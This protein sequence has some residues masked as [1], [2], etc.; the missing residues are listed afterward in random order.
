V[1]CAVTCPAFTNVVVRALPFHCTTEPLIK[2]LP[3]TVSVNP[4]EPALL[5]FGTSDVSAGTGLF[6]AVTLKLTELE[7]PPPGPGFVTTTAGVPTLAMS[8][9]C[10]A[11]V[12]CPALTNVTALPTPP[13]VAVAP[14][15]KL[16]PFT[17]SVNPAEPAAMLAGTSGGVITGTGLFAAVTLKLTELEAPPPGV[18]FVTMTAGVPTLAMSLA[19]TTIVTCPELTKV[20]ALLA[21]PN[22]AVAPF[23]KLDPFTVSVN[24]APPAVA[25]EG[26]NGGVITG[27]GLFTAKLTEFDAPPPGPGFVTTT[28]GV[29]AVAIS[30]ARTAIV[31]CPE[32]TKVTALLTPPNVAVAPFTKFDPFTVSVNAAPPAIA[33]AGAS[34]AVITGTGL[35]TVK[36][37]EFEA[38]PPG[39]GFVTITAGV[40]ATAM[41]LTRIEAFTCPEFTKAVILLMPP[42]LTV[43]PLRK[44][45]PFTVNVKAAPPAIT[46]AGCNVVTVGT[47]LFVTVTLK[48]TEFDV[49]P[50]GVG[51]VT[52][53]PGVPAATMSLVKM[54]AVTFPAFTNDVMRGLPLKFTI[55]PFT[56]LDPLTVKV[57]PCPPAAADDGCSVVTVGTGLPPGPV[58]LNAKELE[59]CPSGFFTVT[60]G[61]P[62]LATSAAGITASSENEL[63]NIVL[64]LLPLKI[65]TA[66]FTKFEPLTVRINSAEPA[67]T[68]D[69][70][71]EPI[72]GGGVVTMKLTEFDGPPPGVG[73]VTT[74][75]GVPGAAIS[76]ARM[77]T[78][79]FVVLTNVVDRALPPKVTAEVGMNPVPFTVN[80]NAG[81]PV[82]VPVG[83]S[84]V[85]AG[86]GFSPVIPK[87]TVFET[88]PPG[89]GFV[90][91]TVADPT[92]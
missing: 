75:A 58:T 85:I 13:N 73:F 76:A 77:E 86:T 3:F 17:V 61:V 32:L 89:T 1:I 79:S 65:T 29:P 92:N 48:V 21:P 28:A 45:V 35:F 60:P 67:I 37:T 84:D 78:V 19:C 12:T 52:V 53:T 62:T 18:G 56:K 46:F 10:T 82:V 9:A 26:T 59:I 34:G 5:V 90:A 8:L 39:P 42:K 80:V 91:V 33:L 41:S 25:P 55:A 30:A 71:S 31:T 22:V 38:P 23:T 44:F 43:A 27:T 2:L 50:P 15:T 87:L 14:F 72:A 16:D 54:E 6:A 57:N 20:T 4:P 70:D 11:I 66:P 63:R 47:G 64:S 88:P 40:P 74:T 81:E 24:A 51:F 49:P 36:L 83:W 68:P 7:A 69:G